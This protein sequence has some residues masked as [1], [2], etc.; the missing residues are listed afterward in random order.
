MSQPYLWYDATTQPHTTS[1]PAYISSTHDKQQNELQ[2]D[3]GNITVNSIHSISAPSHH[4]CTWIPDIAITHKVFFLRLDNISQVPH[5]DQ[6][7]TYFS[8]PLLAKLKPS[9]AHCHNIQTSLHNAIKPM[10]LAHDQLYKQCYH[11]FQI[12][13]NAITGV[14]WSYFSYPCALAEKFRFLNEGK[15]DEDREELGFKDNTRLPAQAGIHSILEEDLLNLDKTP[16]QVL[17]E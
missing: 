12:I 3:V 14:W 6:R 9:G 5:V 4:N 11:L 7:V 16:I 1:G 13:L 10:N 2:D 8:L 15:E 17:Q